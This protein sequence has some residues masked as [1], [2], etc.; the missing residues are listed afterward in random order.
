MA[1]CCRRSFGNR[2]VVMNVMLE[3]FERF[4][5]LCCGQAEE[6]PESNYGGWLYSF[7]TTRTSKA[8]S[9]FLP[10]GCWSS[11]TSFGALYLSKGKI[12]KTH[13]QFQL[14]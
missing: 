13:L 1:P 8:E 2:M 11:S 3:L 5:S 9:H 12:V 4:V 7:M 10:A 6:L 14:A